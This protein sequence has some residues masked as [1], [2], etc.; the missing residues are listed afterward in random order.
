[1]TND[2]VRRRDL[3]KSVL[4]GAGISLLGRRSSS[5]AEAETQQAGSDTAPEQP[6][7]AVDGQMAWLMS[8]YP[9]GHLTK[10][11][12]AEI[13]QDVE[14]KLQQ[15]KLLRQYPIGPDETPGLVFAAYRG[16]DG[17]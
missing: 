1:M 9:L 2:S 6:L 3:A 5:G 17:E 4:A 8:R 12:L 14:R 11:E 7:S 10:E 15:S 13:R 16:P